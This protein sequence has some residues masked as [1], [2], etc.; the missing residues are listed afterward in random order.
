M[1]EPAAVLDECIERQAEPRAAFFDADSYASRVKAWSGSERFEATR[2]DRRSMP[3][4]IFFAQNSMGSPK[5][6]TP[7]PLALR[8][9]PAE[10]P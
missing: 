8:C 3:S 7:R 5:T 2:G 9:A 4:G 1:T 10:S 6:Q